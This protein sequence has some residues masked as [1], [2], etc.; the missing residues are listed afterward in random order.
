M[1]KVAA[2]WLVLTSLCAFAQLKQ[3]EKPW[4]EYVYQADGFAIRAPIAAEIHP[5][6]QSPDVTVYAWKLE[7]GVSLAIHVGM[8]AGCAQ[9][10]ANMKK[11]LPVK[12][13]S[14]TGNPGVESQG[15]GR[16]GAPYLERMFC[17]GET[18]YSLTGEWAAGQGRPEMLDRMF[19]SF[20]FVSK[21]AK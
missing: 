5:D 16:T 10:L 9:T 20:R 15:R 17:S 21:E 2:A 18:G 8:R 13:V 19:D 12:E 4:K 11:S 3:E 1:S 14:V 7:S 6:R